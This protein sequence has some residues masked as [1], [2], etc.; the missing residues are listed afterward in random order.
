MLDYDKFTLD[1]GLRVLVHRDSS[2]PLVALNLLYDVGARDE[3]PERTG[4]AH[5][6]EHLMFGG[7]TNIPVFDEPL[8][9]AGGTNNAFTSNDITNYYLS[10]PRQ[11]LEMAFWLESD[12][13]LGLNLTTK[14]IET[15][16]KVVI[17]EFNQRYLNQPYGDAWLSLRPMAYQHHPYS[18]PTIGKEISHIQNATEVDVK[19]FFNLHYCPSNAIL[20]I[21]GDVSTEEIKALAQK[22]FGPIQRNYLYKRSLPKEPRQTAKRT[23]TVE[24]KVPYDALYMVFHMPERKHKDYYACDLLSDILS[25]GESARLDQKLVR[26]EQLFSEISAYISGDSDEGLFVFS[27]KVYEG[28]DIHKAE[29]GLRRELDDI[30]NSSIDSRELEKVKNRMEVAMAWSELKVTDKALNL[31]YF[32]LMGAASLWNEEVTKY[33]A[34]DAKQIQAVANEIFREDNASILYYLAEKES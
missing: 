4:F 7:S 2:T 21:A 15:Q 5:L 32:E 33:Q 20:A 10:V 17:E 25:A 9:R 1:N 24:N 18:W 6:F 34:V 23:K 11:N 27:G 13:M 12:R 19:A 8:E 26:Q 14:S 28:V 3:D 29:E 30:M 22:W 31:C 16:K